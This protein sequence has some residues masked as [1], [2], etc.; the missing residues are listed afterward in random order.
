MT[1]ITFIAP[2]SRILQTFAPMLDSAVVRGSHGAQRPSAGASPSSTSASGAS[3]GPTEGS[4]LLSS[5]AAIH[6]SSSDASF[7]AALWHMPHG[8]FPSLRSDDGPREASIIAAS[9][10]RCD[11]SGPSNSLA[12]PIILTMDYAAA[13]KGKAFWEKAADAEP[14]RLFAW[15]LA[16]LAGPGLLTVFGEADASSLTTIA[17][18]GL[19]YGYLF[20]PV[21]LAFVPILFLAQDLSL[22]LGVHTQSGLL[23]SIRRTY[24]PAAAWLFCAGFV[25]VSVGELVSLVCGVATVGAIWGWPHWAGVL[26]GVA[27]PTIAVS[28]CS[29]A[30]KRDS[31]PPAHASIRRPCV[32]GDLPRH[33][34][35][36]H[37]PRMY[38]ACMHARRY[39]TLELVGITISL[40]LVSFVVTTVASFAKFP[41][42]VPMRTIVDWPDAMHHG[43]A[44]SVLAA[45]LGNVL[46]PWMLC[47]QQGAIVARGT[48]PGRSEA[49][50]RTDTLIGAVGV[51][52][53]MCCVIITMATVGAIKGHDTTLTSVQQVADALGLVLGNRLAAKVLVT[54]AFLGGSL[55]GTFAVGLAVSWALCDAAGVVHNYAL[56]T[57]FAHNRTFYAGFYACNALAA[58]VLALT[59][60]YVSLFFF[61]GTANGLF[62]PLGLATTFALSVDA[63]VMPEAYRPRGA[64]RAL[65]GGLIL[66]IALASWGS[67]A[68]ACVGKR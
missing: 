7:L 3:H 63:R 51:Q 11:T 38:H 20:I 58:L 37:A 8:W 55:A 59:R 49:I 2:R 4:A 53:I 28:T 47:F 15:D 40:A 25:C 17:A 61:T 12:D 57:S 36:T 5:P 50:E 60:D 23:A 68:L 44:F 46:M 67:I 31:Q 33:A 64:H 34:C 43:H 22:R 42:V 27:V 62:L 30:H 39:R 52:M 48:T 45:N 56:T 29:Y 19:G 66:L 32:P 26:F 6:R 35:T 14:R 18:A 54:A 1:L 24:G 21:M 16:A 41:N 13:E 65:I 10:S 9:G